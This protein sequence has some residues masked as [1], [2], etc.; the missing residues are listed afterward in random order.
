MKSAGYR[1][2]HLLELEK[3]AEI[4]LD[5]HPLPSIVLFSGEMGV[6]K[7]TFIA[8]I[9]KALKVEDEVS[10]PSYS[11]VNEYI[12]DKGEKVYHFDFYRLNDPDE[13]LDFG[14]EEYFDSGDWCFV[15]WPEMLDP[16]LPKDAIHVEMTMKN[17]DRKINWD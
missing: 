4:F 11:L 16:H 2:N 10:S 6:G 7:T 9:C 1:I 5:A 13:A 17:G 3:L 15:E 14:V 8:Q 12:N